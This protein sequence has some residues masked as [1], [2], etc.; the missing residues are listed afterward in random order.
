M[1]SQNPCKNH[2]VQPKSFTP[3]SVEAESSPEGFQSQFLRLLCC[4]FPPVCHGAC[5]GDR[6]DAIIIDIVMT[7]LFYFLYSIKV[8]FSQSKGSDSR[9]WQRTL[10]NCCL[11]W[12]SSIKTNLFH[13]NFGCYLLLNE[14]TPLLFIVLSKMPEIMAGKE[15]SDFVNFSIFFC[16]HFRLWRNDVRARGKW[17]HTIIRFIGIFELWKYLIFGVG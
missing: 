6:Y 10:W 4:R 2:Q 17:E 3:C 5:H 15:M 13:N 14:L 1:T 7:K 9:T 8:T 16:W 11:V 12:L